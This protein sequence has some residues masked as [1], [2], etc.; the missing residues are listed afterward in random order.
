MHS[1]FLSTLFFLMFSWL[2]ALIM[3]LP[4]LILISLYI[5]VMRLIVFHSSSDW[6][7]V[8]YFIQQHTIHNS[9]DDMQYSPMQTQHHIPI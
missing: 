6:D 2:T 1:Y 8:Q 7:I 9:Q 3:L 5:F 4:V